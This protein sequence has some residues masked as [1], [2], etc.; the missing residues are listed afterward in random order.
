MRSTILTLSLLLFALTTTADFLLSN[1]TICMAAFPFSTCHHGP[2]VLSGTSNTTAYTCPNLLHALESVYVYNGIAG[3]NGSP[4]LWAM[5]GAC[6]VEGELHF[7]L[8]GVT[9]GYKGFKGEGGEAVAD[10]RVEEGLA[11]GCSQWVGE[12]FFESQYWCSSASISC[13]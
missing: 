2:S 4:D 6:G 10:C 7:V 13:S 1:S 11:R 8:D 3:P 9:G 12:V 5:P